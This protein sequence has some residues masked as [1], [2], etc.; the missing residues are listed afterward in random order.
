MRCLMESRDYDLFDY[1]DFD[2]QPLSLQEA[3]R[4]AASLRAANHSSVF[5]VVPVDSEMSAFRVLSTPVE[6]A[7]A[8]FLC[9]IAGAW[10]RIARGAHDGSRP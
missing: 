3:T 7:Y 10:G 6:Q 2:E 5:R 8:Q 9:R 1:R 4:R